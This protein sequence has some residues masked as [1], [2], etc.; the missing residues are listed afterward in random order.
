MTQEPETSAEEYFHQTY[1]TRIW[2]DYKKEFQDTNPE[3]DG[4]YEVIDSEDSHESMIC[5]SQIIELMEELDEE[6]KKEEVVILDTAEKI[7]QFM[8]VDV[9]K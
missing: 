6:E 9:H 1:V 7:F 2:E 3:L 4:N 8:V 5:P